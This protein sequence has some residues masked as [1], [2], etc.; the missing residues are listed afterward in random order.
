MKDFDS[1]FFAPLHEKMRRDD[2]YEQAE[3]QFVGSESYDEQLGWFMFDDD[4]NP[5]GK[6]EEDFLASPEFARAVEALAEDLS[7][8]NYGRDYDDCYR[9]PEPPDWFV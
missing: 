3:E 7:D 2:L 4:G 9:E 6:T 8:P 5:T 1:W